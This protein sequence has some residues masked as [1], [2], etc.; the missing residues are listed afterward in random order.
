MRGPTMSAPE[1]LRCRL[2]RGALVAAVVLAATPFLWWAT[3]MGPL[4]DDHGHP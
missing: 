2:A 4:E 1:S 3:L